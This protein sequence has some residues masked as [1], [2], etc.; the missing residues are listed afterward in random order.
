MP[1]TSFFSGL[2]KDYISNRKDAL[3]G[4]LKGMFDDVSLQSP[5]V[6]EQVM[7]FISSGTPDQLSQDI[8]E[9]AD[10]NFDAS[11]NLDDEENIFSSYQ[12]TIMYRAAQKN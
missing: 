6:V 12:C 8:E 7:D 2:D 1:K 4:Y 3:N 5:E 10:S 11:S 9:E